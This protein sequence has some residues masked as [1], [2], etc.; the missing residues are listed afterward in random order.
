MTILRTD[1]DGA[2]RAGI[3]RWRLFALVDPEKALRPSEQPAPPGEWNGAEPITPGDR[4]RPRWA[5]SDALDVQLHGWPDGRLE[6]EGTLQH[7]A[8]GEATVVLPPLRAGAWRL[9]YDTRDPLGGV[10]RVSRDFLVAGKK[11]PLRLAGVLLSERDSVGVGE[12]A[13]LLAFSGLPDQ[14]FY[15]ETLRDGRVISRRTLVGAEDSLIELP[16]RDEDRG[17]MGFRLSL[18]T[19]HQFVS[20]SAKVFVPWDDKQLR[21]SFSTFRDR[22]RPGTRETWR[23]AVTSPP[24][25]AAEERV[26]ELLAEMYD[27]SLDAFALSAPPNPVGLYPDRSRAGTCRRIS[28]SR[29]GCGSSMTISSRPGPPNHFAPTA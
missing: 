1:L 15:L 26:A 2:P 13:R 7:D 16:I 11:T 23:V 4:E 14:P 8:K 3:G 17:G 25:A 22:I 20:A 24:G 5:Q 29:A 21:V 9:R 10:A 27:R 18:V 28:A 12:T 19:D 6:A